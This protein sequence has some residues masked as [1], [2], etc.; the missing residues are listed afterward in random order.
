M[1]KLTINCIFWIGY[2]MIIFA[3]MFNNI[4]FLE[5]N[6]DFITLIGLIIVCGYILIKNKS[7]NTKFVLIFSFVIFISILTY[8]KLDDFTILKFMMLLL[9]MKTIDFSDFVKHDFKIRI[10]MS[11]MVFLCSC[12]GLCGVTSFYRE[13]TVR[14]T[15][16]FIHPNIAGFY[17][18]LIGA[19]YI[20]INKAK[21]HFFIIPIILCAIINFITDSRTSLLAM[22][23]IIL[24]SCY[25]KFSK[26]KLGNNRIIRIIIKNLFLIITCFTIVVIVL[27]DKQN[28]FALFINNKFSNRLTYFSYFWNNYSANILGNNLTSYYVLDNAYLQLILRY[29][30]IS[31]I[32]YYIMYKKRIDKAFKDTDYYLI[33]IM[34][35][36]MVYGF[37]ENAMYKST[38]NIFLLSFSDVIFKKNKGDILE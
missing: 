19:E 4:P 21:K 28:N 27:F 22:I 25:V 29:G 35:C 1:R 10:F 23:L 20:Y 32:F 18:L 6:N 30:L 15:L 24:G 8:L 26:N 3:E 17:M 13:G 12:I 33:I 11:I 14:Y 34:V 7:Y 16:G 38:Y 5:K 2:T 31:Y 36:M 9:A 37:T